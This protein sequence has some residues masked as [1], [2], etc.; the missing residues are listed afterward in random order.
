M[1]LPTLQGISD[2]P[3]WV[4][5]RANQ[6]ARM[7]GKT[8]FSIYQGRWNV[9][10]R[11]FEREIIPMARAEGMALAP[12]NVLV[13]GKIRTDEEERKRR[14]TGEHGQ[15][16][17]YYYIRYATRHDA[18]RHLPGRTLSSYEWERTEAERRVCKVLEE[19]AA[20]VGT[21]SIQAGTSVV[22]LQRLYTNADLPCICICH[23]SLSRTSCRRSRMSSRSS[24]AARSSTSPAT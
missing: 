9:M 19:V 22:S 6:Y 1:I 23:Q 20:E 4:A 24:A 12:F 13:N 5:A 11:D 16:Y 18:E 17:Y 2:A 15:Y 14:E 7:S 3:A 8:P 21:K 10:K